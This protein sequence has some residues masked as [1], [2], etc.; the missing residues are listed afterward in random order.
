MPWA[1]GQIRLAARNPRRRDLMG[2]VEWRDRR[3]RPARRR[4]PLR[5]DRRGG[6]RRRPRT[7][8]GHRR[9]RRPAAAGRAGVRRRPASRR[10]GTCSAATS[11]RPATCCCTTTTAP[12]RDVG[13]R[14]DRPVRR[15]AGDRHAGAD[16]RHRRRRDEPRAVRPGV[17]RDRHPHHAEPAGPVRAPEPRPSTDRLCVEIGSDSSAHRS[18][19]HVDAVV[20]D[21][22]TAAQD[23]ALPR[24]QAGSSAISAPS[25]SAPCST[26][27]RRRSCHEPRRAGIQLFRIGDAVAGRN[28]HAAVY[29]A[30]RLL[31]DV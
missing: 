30:L 21:R 29:D 19:R 13:G 7:G 2:I 5:R 24:P 28:I 16:A 4:D 31:K 20:V 6:R 18:V 27:G 15:P 23:C 9:H 22:G 8:R 14:D 1:G 10:A 25:T 11:R 3:A 17:Q 12:T 26:A